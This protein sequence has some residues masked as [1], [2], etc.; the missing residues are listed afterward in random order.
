MNSDATAQ[1][2]NPNIGDLLNV[3]GVTRGW[4]QGGF[5]PTTAATGTTPAVCGAARTVHEFPSASPATV[6]PDPVAP[7]LTGADIQTSGAD[8]VSHHEPFQF[9]ASTRNPHHLPPE[10]CRPCPS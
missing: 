9:Y 2:G 10:I 1:T 6:V 5:A 3:A 7:F 8:Y 4:F